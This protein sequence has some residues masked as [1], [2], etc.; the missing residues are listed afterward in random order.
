MT[1]PKF[2]TLLCEARRQGEEESEMPT[3]KPSHRHDATKA[4]PCR[5]T[6]HSKLITHHS[7]FTLIELM[8]VILIIAVLVALGVGA[9][10][11]LMGQADVS[12]TRAGMA[13]LIN[14]IER[15][16]EVTDEY[17]TANADDDGITTTEDSPEDE[18]FRQA[19]SEL[20]SDMIDRSVSSSTVTY[21][22]IDA[23]GANMK[24][25]KTGG[26]G[27]KPRIT[28]PGPDANMNTK[29]DNIYSD[30]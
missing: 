19:I 10:M 25:E 21:T 3:P 28:S 26:L 22:F 23:F 11:Y 24:Y 4:A 12:K 14:A 13:I 17:P 15:Y 9:G 27:G 1:N 18:A 2:K 29:G 8:V 20:P 30:K 7:G 6:P 5:C 16:R